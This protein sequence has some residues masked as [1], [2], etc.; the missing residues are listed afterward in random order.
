[1]TTIVTAGNA[2]TLLFAG[3]WNARAQHFAQ[4]L[5]WWIQV[6]LEEKCANRRTAQMS[7][8]GWLQVRLRCLGLQFNYRFPACNP[9][10]TRSETRAIQS[11]HPVMTTRETLSFQASEAAEGCGRP[12]GLTDAKL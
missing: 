2:S 4:D 7:Q 12:G 6:C 5:E 8:R 1:M 3:A 10:T 9:I 11:E